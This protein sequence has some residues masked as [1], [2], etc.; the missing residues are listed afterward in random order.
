M[1]RAVATSQNAL[2]SPIR[3]ALRHLSKDRCHPQS[4]FLVIGH[5]PSLS[6]RAVP[7]GFG[8]H[9]SR[10]ACRSVRRLAH[11]L[12]AIALIATR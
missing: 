10:A 9:A 6:V 4:I 11:S 3:A 5:W 7:A 12:P 1:A 2:R 8:G